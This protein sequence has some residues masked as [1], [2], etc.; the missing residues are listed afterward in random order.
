MRTPMSRPFA[1]CIAALAA[2]VVAS[3]ASD[4][5]APGD[6]WTGGDPARLTADKADCQKDADGL[7]VNNASN[8][9]DGRYGVTA[10]MA[11]AIAQNDPL[12]DQ[13]PAIRR[14]AFETCMSDKG[15]KLQ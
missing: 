8:Y 14:A 1:A 12:T 4:N 3:S 15:W 6:V 7:D 13:G 10:A 11:E 2:V 5:K 9:S